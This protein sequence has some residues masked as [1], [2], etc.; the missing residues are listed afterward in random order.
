VNQ[1]IK[2]NEM[3]RAIQAAYR[4]DEVK[5]IHDQAVALELYSR[6]ARN[7]DLEKQCAEIRI[8]AGRRVG[9][10][11]KEREMA[12]GGRPAKNR[13]RETTGLESPAPLSDLGISKDQSSRWQQLA[14]MPDETF[15]EALA[16]EPVKPTTG[17]V[18][19]FAKPPQAEKQ[20]PVDP[21][22]NLALRVWGIA[23]DIS[24]LA[25]EAEPRAM[26]EAMT[27]VMIADAHGWLEIAA[28][29]ILKLREQVHDRYERD[30]LAGIAEKLRAA[31]SGTRCDKR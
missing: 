26:T 18:L 25:R 27:D 30:G 6:Q 12:K 24:E 23:R 3:C 22:K 10:L 8:R 28:D 17:A 4:I 9:Q 21:V 7:H 16:S 2:Y 31:T 20:A 14:D 19:N 5:K 29:W 11:L 1:L 15:E 13:S